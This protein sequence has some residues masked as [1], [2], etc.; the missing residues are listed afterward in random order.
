MESTESEPASV[1]AIGF[2]LQDKPRI[3]V[4]KLPGPWLLKHTTPVWRIRD[5]EQ[6]FQRTVRED[7]AR[8]IAATVL[9]QHRTFPN[10][11]I[12]ATDT[13]VFEEERGNLSISNDTRFLV[14]DGQH[15][16]WAQKYS[17]FEASFCCMLHMQLTEAEMARLFLEIN[18]NQRRVP[19]S[20]RWDLLRLVKPEDKKD[21]KVAADLTYELATDKDSPLFQRIDLTGEQAEIDLKQASVAPEVRNI[22][23]PKKSPLYPLDFDS[24]FDILTRYFA[25]IKSRDPSGWKS[26]KSRLYGAR[27]LRAL[28]RLLPEIIDRMDKPVM[29]VTARDYK[30]F[31]NRLRLDTLDLKKIRFAQGSSGVAIITDIVRKQIL[32]RR[33]RKAKRN[34]R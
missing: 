29:D 27:V 30:E 6:G 32:P 19:P 5:P 2:V 1:Q 28:I 26:S 34:R 24:Q 16:L 22:I 12:L 4:A 17:Q 21:E 20:L 10:A 9:D 23:A 3:Y 13:S 8:A 18:N 14:V 25:A 11:I 15:R 31:L 33:K 7:R